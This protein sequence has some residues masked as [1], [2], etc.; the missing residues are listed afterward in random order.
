MVNNP[1]SAG[2]TFVGTIC[3]G[4][5]FAIPVILGYLL[6]RSIVRSVEKRKEKLAKQQTVV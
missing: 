6:V 1:N 3:C 2:W 5:V 4:F